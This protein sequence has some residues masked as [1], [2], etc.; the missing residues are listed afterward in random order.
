MTLDKFRALNFVNGFAVLE[1]AEKAKINSPDYTGYIKDYN[2][3]I[4]VVKLWIEGKYSYMQME[5]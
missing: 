3:K 4:R 5:G 2:G 1:P